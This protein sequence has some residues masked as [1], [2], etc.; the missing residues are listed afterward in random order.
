MSERKSGDDRIL[1]GSELIEEGLRDL[2]EN[3]TTEASLLLLVAA[4]RL[5]E[6][7][8]DVPERSFARPVEHELY[9]L[10]EERLGDAAHSHY[11]SLLRRVA[12]YIHAL[13]RERSQSLR[14]V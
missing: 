3:R 5:R 4:P 8:I 14:E 2:K 1:P 10:I 9:E 11:N 13:E 7:G 12:S 6:L